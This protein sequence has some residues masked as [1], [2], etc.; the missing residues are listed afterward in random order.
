M[1]PIFIFLYMATKGISTSFQLETFPMGVLNSVIL[2]F[3]WLGWKIWHSIISDIGTDF[4]IMLTIKC[5]FS[6]YLIKINYRWCSFLSDKCNTEIDCE[7]KS[8]EYNCDYLRFG[9]NYAKELIPRD[10][11]GEIFTVYL[12]VS[13]LA[14]PTINTVSL[15][16]TSDFYLNLRWYDLRI[17]YQVRYEMEKKRKPIN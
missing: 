17:D 10:E 12:N 1:V 16:F 3:V 8:D 4:I 11:A 7:D 14:I 2:Y 9:A 13:V 5:S 6:F 15:S